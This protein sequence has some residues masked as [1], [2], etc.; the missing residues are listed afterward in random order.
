MIIQKMHWLFKERYNK[1]NSNNYRDLS[2]YQ[3]D[4]KINNSQIIFIEE[5]SYPENT[6]QDLDMVGNLLVTTPEQPVLLPITVSG[7]VYQ[8][9]LSALKYPLL[10][11]KRIVANTNCGNVLIADTQILGHDKLNII[12]DDFHQQPSKKWKRLVAVLAKSSTSL[13]QNLY[14]YSAPGFVVTSIQ[15][16]YIRKPKEVFFGNYNSI[17]YAQ[18]VASGGTNCNQYYNLTA[19]PVDCE[20]DS[21]YHDLIVDYAVREAQRILKDNSIQLTEQKIAQIQAN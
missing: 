7:N 10:R 12:L 5:F 21:R 17:E 14:I 19:P 6:L 8:F 11:I 15:I 13:T 18:C 1:L 20:I 16:D 4:E 9:N 3:I 2:P